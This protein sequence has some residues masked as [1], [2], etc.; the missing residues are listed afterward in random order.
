MARSTSLLR[1]AT[2]RTATL[3]DKLETFR[4]LRRPIIKRT[5]A[6]AKNAAVNR[7]Q[8]KAELG[9]REEQVVNELKALGVGTRHA[10]P[11]P[12]LMMS[13]NK[14]S[15]FDVTLKRNVQGDVNGLAGFRTRDPE[16]R[17]THLTNQLFCQL[18]I[19]FTKINTDSELN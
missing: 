3:W 15:V 8:S 14:R 12:P 4:A 5:H 2:T 18:H 1:M 17:Y 6:A 10:T 11:P 16:S 9:D 13:A 19:I 7:G